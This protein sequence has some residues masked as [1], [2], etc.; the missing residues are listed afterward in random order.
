MKYFTD[1]HGHTKYF[2]VYIVLLILLMISYFGP[3]LEIRAITLITAFG[4]AIIK[5]IMVCAFF[6]H[7]NVEKK[8]IWFLLMTVVLLLFVFFGGTAGDIMNPDG[9]NW[10]HHAYMPAPGEYLNH[11]DHADAG[12][13][14]AGGDHAATTDAHESKSEHGEAHGDKH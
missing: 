2:R 12:D 7:L 14:A 8:Y 1:E 11:G 13:H 6:M 5:T 4:I 3:M 9:R 10:R